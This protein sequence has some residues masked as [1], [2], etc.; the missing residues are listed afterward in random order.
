MNLR[1]NNS[2]TN[3]YE[4]ENNYTILE[5]RP[6]ML[7]LE[8]TRNCN[9]YC[10]MCRPYNLYRNDWVM[11][12]KTLLKIKQQ[13]LPYVE[14]IDLRGF[15][16]SSMDKR[17]VD[18]AKEFNLNGV[19]TRLYT[20][21]CTQTKEYWK[22]LINTNISLAIS[23]ETSDPIKYSKIRRGGNFK[24]MR[25]N[26]ISIMDTSPETI[27]YF[28]VVLSNNNYKD[29]IGLIDFAA[30]VG[31]KLIE[32]NPISKSN[33]NEKLPKYGFEKTQN[34][35]HNELIKISDYSIHKGIN[36]NIAANCFN[37]NNL[38][39]KKCI[40]PWSY[41]CV[42][43]DGEIGFCDHL[44]RDDA[45]MFGNINE[46]SF[47]EIWNNT[48]YQKLRKEHINEDFLKLNNLGLECSWCKN[49]RYA[50]FETNFNNFFKQITIQD[51][52]KMM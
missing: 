6:R 45:S 37:E 47:M 36:V 41:V 25:D 51:Y 35:I 12:E 27:P 18:L 33:K 42:R 28:S 31:I 10:S 23:I 43:Y 17:L 14:V 50:N 52:I 44:I 5:S 8:L 21:L 48:K 34:N 40:H 32:L 11:S 22:N 30:E 20:N 3:S 2:K 46:Y 7:F 4:Y 13:L 38:K 26:L 39:N 16:E 1:T 49:N 15:G 19:K 29:I 24:V 9:L